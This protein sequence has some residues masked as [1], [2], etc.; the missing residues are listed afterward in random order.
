MSGSDD[1]KRFSSSDGM[2]LKPDKTG[3]F[4]LFLQVLFGSNWNKKEFVKC[5]HEFNFKAGFHPKWRVFVSLL[6]QKVL[7]NKASMFK[8]VGDITE[9]LLNPK[10]SS[11]N[12]LFML[13]FNYMRGKEILD[14]SSVHYISI[15][16]HM[17]KRLELLDDTIKHEDPIKY[18]AA[19]SMMASKVSYENKAFVRD[20][21]V[22]KWKKELVDPCRDYW[23]DF[24]EKATTQAF[25][26]LDKGEEQDTYVVA[27]RGTE[28]FDADAWST[29]VDIS[30]FELPGVGKAHAGFMKALGFPVDFDNRIVSWPKE[31][32]S[33]DN[34][35]VSWPDEEMQSYDKN[36]PL[37][38][39]YIR[40]L[41]KKHLKRNNKAKFILT[42][43]S[44][45][46]ALAILFASML[47]V[48]DE[49]CLLKRLEGV[50]TFGQP[51]VGDKPFALYM[52]NKFKQ[53]DVKYFRFV[54]CNDIVPRLPFD[55][56]IM[57]FEHLRPGYYYDRNYE[58]Q[59]KEEELN[60]NYFAWN[61]I[62]KN[63]VNAFLEL[64]RSFTIVRKFGPAYK[65]G[66]LQ[67]GFRFFGFLTIAG[68]PAHG[69]QD[70]VNVTRLGLHMD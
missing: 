70:Y 1:E 12:N 52:E 25:I 55:N 47:I 16:G 11:N 34:G 65:E 30:W 33:Y 13:L 36:C 69:P 32:Q 51:R 50:Y 39:Y 56:D 24:Q 29:D 27:F 40:N 37:A 46:G 15:I 28:P 63:K 19:L 54:Y 60:K 14:K 4:Q 20:V 8:F 18:N 6:A 3:Y 61:A 35:I 59:K 26:M 21:V 10:A 41:L 9:S 67:I 58:G 53:Y 43:H 49:E 23:N 66:W 31:M 48:H 5:H 45:G 22:D 17:D 62:M 2:F 42:G 64:V 68:L 57:K 7:H 44:L 38:Y